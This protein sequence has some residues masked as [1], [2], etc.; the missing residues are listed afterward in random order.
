MDFDRLE[1][2]IRWLRQSPLR[3]LEISEGDAHIHLRKADIS[4][5]DL[6]DKEHGSAPQPATGPL[7]ARSVP[8]QP[9]DQQTVKSP[10]YGT[11]HLTPK[12]G[13]PPFVQLG[14]RVAAGQT[15]CLIEAMKVFNPVQSDLAGVVAGI[16][17]Q[18]G[19]EVEPDQ[20]LFRIEP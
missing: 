18:S 2:I 1:R 20:P 17:V 14:Q 16:L 9:L 15:L 7:T 8:L 12:A 19:Q 5:Q 11:C 6:S 4:G 3:E 10:L 13:E